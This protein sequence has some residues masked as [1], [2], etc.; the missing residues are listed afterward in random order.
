MKAETN[1]LGENEGEVTIYG[2]GG[3]VDTYYHIRKESLE[4][5][6]P[7]VWM[8]DEFEGGKF[9]GEAGEHIETH[10]LSDFADNVK[11]LEEAMRAV[12]SWH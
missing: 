3:E 6:G 1:T 11:T 2:E 12:A 8:V 10:V 4:E 5:G 9:E 7:P